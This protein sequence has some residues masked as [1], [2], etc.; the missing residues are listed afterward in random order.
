MNSSNPIH[1]I[2]KIQDLLNTA[3]KPTRLNI[4]DESAKHANHLAAKTHGGGHFALFINS[5]SF[6]DLTLIEKH[7]LIYKILHPLMST[8]IHALRIIIDNK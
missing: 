5:P 1:T 4:I 2:Q 7:K 8:E 3:L 6:N